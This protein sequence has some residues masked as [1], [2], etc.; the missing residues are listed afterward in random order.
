MLFLSQPI[1]YQQKAHP[2]I[3]TPSLHRGLQTF[4][5]KFNR[6]LT[7]LPLTQMSLI[8]LSPLMSAMAVGA[9]LT[10]PPLFI[11]MSDSGPYNAATILQ[12]IIQYGLQ[13]VRQ[14]WCASPLSEANLKQQSMNFFVAFSSVK[15]CIVSKLFLVMVVV[16]SAAASTKYASAAIQMPLKILGVSRTAKKG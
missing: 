11:G 10:L 13:V 3:F 1:L 12:Y 6:S 16:L 7:W 14:S 2:R 9:L 4:L 15:L 5:H 8:S